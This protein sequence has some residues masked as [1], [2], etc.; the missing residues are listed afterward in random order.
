MRDLPGKVD[1]CWKLTLV[2]G[3]KEFLLE[4]RKLWTEVTL[5]AAP[6]VN[7]LVTIE[8]AATSIGKLI[9]IVLLRRNPSIG[10]GASGSTRGRLCGMAACR[11]V[12][13]AAGGLSVAVCVWKGT[14]HGSSVEGI[15]S[16][17][18]SGAPGRAGGIL[19]SP[20]R[21]HAGR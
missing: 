16:R 6:V 1:A 14:R 4:L 12:C 9:V 5:L 10:N 15:T 21:R 11:V 18:L 13:R 7:S 8:L 3:T 19:R 17:L 2:S 20:T